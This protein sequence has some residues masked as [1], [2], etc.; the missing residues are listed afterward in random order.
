MEDELTIHPIG[1]VS[2]HEDGAALVLDSRYRDA[3]QALDGFSHVQVIWWF[4]D[5]D[6]AEARSVL[7]VPKPYTHAPDTM[8]VLATRSPVRPNPLG[9][10]TVQVCSIDHERGAIEVAYI[11]AHDGTPILDI[12]PYTPSIDRVEAPNVPAWCGHW[13]RSVEESGDFDWEAEFTF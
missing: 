2:V 3:L 10:T 8:G 9:L 12:K 11:D 6:T 4:S 1:R 5:F 13:P 7:E